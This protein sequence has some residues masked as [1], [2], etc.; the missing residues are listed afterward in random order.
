MTSKTFSTKKLIIGSML[1]MPKDDVPNTNTN[2][3]HCKSN[4]E[5]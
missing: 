2:Y 1:Q 3:Q 5:R 4:M